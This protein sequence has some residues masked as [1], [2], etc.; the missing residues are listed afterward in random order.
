MVYV[1]SDLAK[2]YGVSEYEIFSKL[3]ENEDSFMDEVKQDLTLTPKALEIMDK[4]FDYREPAPD[5]AEISD[6]E[7]LRLDNESLRSKVDEL[8]NALEKE[9]NTSSDY[10]KELQ[11]L[12]KQL[13]T[14]KDNNEINSSTLIN[15]YKNTA[16][17]YEKLY[18][19]LQ[20][21][22]TQIKKQNGERIAE[23]ERRIADY[24]ERFKTLDTLKKQVFVSDAKLTEASHKESRLQSQLSQKT[25]EINALILEKSRAEEMAQ[26]AV[27]QA[28]LIK[29]YMFESADKLEAV[30]KNIRTRMDSEQLP[31]MNIVASMAEDPTVPPSQELPV[32]EKK[33]DKPVAPLLSSKKE[34]KNTEAQPDNEI[35]SSEDEKNITDINS[36]SAPLSAGE[37]S[38]VVSPSGAQANGPVIANEKVGN[39]LWDD[40][41]TLQ[42]NRKANKGFLSGL[43]RKASSFLS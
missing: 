37:T 30:V 3:R 27:Q 19:D 20:E 23:Y 4:F 15:K 29:T 21:N 41:E 10:Q 24:D 6:E 28:N 26:Q 2:R 5:P 7:K 31:V 40:D 43:K 39:I 17:R 36:D 35:V 42:F 12:E 8:T 9:K 32:F 33:F 18:K 16:E 1:A 22:F 14:V 25:S 13:Q 34:E 38:T 11:S